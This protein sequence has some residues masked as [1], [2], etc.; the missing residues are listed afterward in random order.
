MPTP[1][2]TSMR[3]CTWLQAEALL[4][5]TADRRRCRA[6]VLER[7]W[8]LVAGAAV[9]AAACSASTVQVAPTPTTATVAPAPATNDAM[10]AAASHGQP[11]ASPVATTISSPAGEAAPA[12][13][14]TATPSTTEPDLR[15]TLLAGGDVLMD[16]SEAAD[17]DPFAGIEPS[18]DTADIAVVNVEMAIS[19]RGEPADKEFVFRAPPSAAEHI[20]GAGV[21]VANLANNHAGDYGPDALVDT[22]ELLEAEGV[23]ALG[24]GATSPD[25]YRHR[26]IEVRPGVRVAFVGASM[27]VPLDFPATRT[28]AGIASA[29]QRDRVLA[30]VRVA[31]GDADVV[32]AVVH[33]GV[34][35][36][37]CPDGRQRDFAF[38]LLRNGADAVIGQHSHVLQPVVFGDGKLVAYSLGNFVWHYRSGITG[39]T[40]VLQ[41]DFDGDE[42]AGWSFHPH[43]LDISGA[44]VPAAEGGRVDRIND[45]ISGDCARHQPPPITT[46]P[47]P[48][49]GAG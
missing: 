10:D 18:L 27:V 7:A 42:I 39:E 48:V 33:W 6:D 30:N 35:R 13:T 29:Y 12:A 45:I 14:T 20:A 28:R 22:V 41:I 4:N 19:E 15:W 32:I 47:T 9:L 1:T 21:D 8:V 38:E 25:A 24:A 26:I 2:T 46:P 43:L 44:P 31:A 5:S 49:S 40:G 36:M 37:T 17:I 34:E 3:S 23:I 11:A 16:R